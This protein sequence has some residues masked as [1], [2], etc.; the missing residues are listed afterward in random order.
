MFLTPTAGPKN[1]RRGVFNKTPCCFDQNTVLFQVKHHV[2]LTKTPR[3]FDQNS[4]LFF[5]ALQIINN[6]IIRKTIR[7]SLWFRVVAFGSSLELRVIGLWL[8]SRPHPHGVS[9]AHGLE[10][11]N[12][13][14]RLCNT[15]FAVRKLSTL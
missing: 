14:K 11:V 7:S 2:V 12:G 5:L 1:T 6:Q 3:C 10:E 15:K 8:S 9:R 13:A 4:T